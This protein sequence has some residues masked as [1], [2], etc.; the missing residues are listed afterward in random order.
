MSVKKLLTQNLSR[1]SQLSLRKRFGLGL[2]LMLMPFFLMGI[3]TYLFFEQAITNFEEAQSKDLETRFSISELKGHFS[4][5]RPKVTSLLIGQREPA[6][7]EKIKLQHAKITEEIAGIAAQSPSLDQ[8]QLLVGIGRS[9]EKVYRAIQSPVL[10]EAKNQNQIKLIDQIQK[11]LEEVQ[12]GLDR[13]DLVLNDIQVADNIK[14]AQQLKQQ[15]RMWIGLITLL[16]ISIA[17]LSAI[18]LSRSVIRSMQILIS[19]LEKLS[20]GELDE[21]IQ[22]HIDDEF[23][24]IANAINAMAAKLAQNQQEL[25]EI[26]TL[27]GLTGVFNRREFNR[28][29]TI[30]VE[31]SRRDHHPVSMV[32]V[33]IDHFKSINDTYGHQSGD[34]ALQWVSSLLK[35]E[36]RPGDIA[37]R[38]G[39][40]EFALILPNT[41]EADAGVVAERIRFKM[42][43]ELVPLPKGLAIPVTA[44][45]GC[46]T[47]P[48]VGDSEERLMNA[49]DKALYRAKETGRN[50]V[51]HAEPELG[52]LKKELPAKPP[53]QSALR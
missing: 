26:A 34:V 24:R 11:D 44:S 23:G 16:A 15:E 18:F 53:I 46:A 33:D 50:R 13:I 43:S 12:Q 3:S 7:F 17:I 20:E 2:G 30:E 42:E 47:F 21:R 41:D 37:A 40:E 25:I 14:R 4:Q 8:T 49:A 48:H 28:L 38:Y 51:C 6:K 1:A 5:V 45:L 10:A 29:L 35:R 36:I 19:G 9:W 52:E 32:M 22:W 27:D 31:R 39:G